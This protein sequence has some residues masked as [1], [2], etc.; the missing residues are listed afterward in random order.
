MDRCWISHCTPFTPAYLNGIRQFVSF[1]RE[2]NDNDSTVLCPCTKCLNQKR[3]HISG[4]KR[5]LLLN[6]FS[7]TYL[8]W[9]QHG[10]PSDVLIIRDQHDDDYDGNGGHEDDNDGNGGHMDMDDEGEVDG[11]AAEF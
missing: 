5:H 4:L 9:T 3:I 1:V 7:S 8:R 6:K 10:E 11:E 2:R